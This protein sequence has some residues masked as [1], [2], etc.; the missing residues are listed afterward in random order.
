M[1]N[2]TQQI[3][4]TSELVKSPIGLCHILPKQPIE[5]KIIQKNMIYDILKK[6]VFLIICNRQSS[7]PLC[8]NLLV[9]V[10]YSLMVH[11]NYV[12]ICTFRIGLTV[13][14]TLY[15]VINRPRKRTLW[16]RI[17]DDFEIRVSTELTMS[18]EKL[19]KLS[20]AIWTEL[21]RKHL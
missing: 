17:T 19:I 7:S 1:D 21:S 8:D 16:A 14:T 6:F 15:D 2:P 5:Y 11:A 12:F 3:S 4:N 18:S 9:M 20:Y 13:N 10:R